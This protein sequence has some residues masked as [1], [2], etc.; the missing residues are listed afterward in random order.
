MN[1]YGEA[2]Y[3]TDLDYMKTVEVTYGGHISQ[4]RDNIANLL[5][6]NQ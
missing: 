2:D 6:K 5:W 4:I 1:K 3:H